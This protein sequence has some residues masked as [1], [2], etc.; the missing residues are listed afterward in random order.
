M[1]KFIDAAATAP[2]TKTG[3]PFTK[4]RYT[5]SLNI[6]E[7][8]TTIHAHARTKIGARKAAH[9]LAS[10]AQFYLEQA[11]LMPV[12][13]Q[14]LLAQAEG[15]PELPALGSSVY[16]T[17]EVAGLPAG[18]ECLVTE[19]EWNP[20]DEGAAPEN[21]FPIMALPLGTKEEFNPIPLALD[22]F[23]TEVAAK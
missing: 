20:E 19:S 3:R 6:N 16:L 4:Y 11:G 23:T 15:R 14:K 13:Y 7:F 1:P 17:K 10:E 18:T 2:I 21:T 12:I 22:E 5:V 9:A 8:R